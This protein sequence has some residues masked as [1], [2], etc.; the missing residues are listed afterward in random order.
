[1][2]ELDALKDSQ[3]A[4]QG[5]HSRGTVCILHLR[6]TCLPG[7]LT[8]DALS[9]HGT[10]CVVLD[11]PRSSAPRH[12]HC[13][14]GL[15]G[16]Y[17]CTAALLTQSTPCRTH[18]VRWRVWLLRGGVLRLHPRH[19]SGMLPGRGEHLHALRNACT[20]AC[21]TFE[22]GLGSQGA[23]AEHPVLR[24]GTST[25]HNAAQ[26]ASSWHSSSHSPHCRGE[27]CLSMHARERLLPAQP[28]I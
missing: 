23:P 14:P 24:D 5:C 16:S 8:P 3:P 1:M 21:L 10:S 28:F 26:A 20:A 13:H 18:P 6:W 27:M 2:V 12:L 15:Q 17:H 25:L 9:L 7:W 11:S 4:A 19:C 22:V